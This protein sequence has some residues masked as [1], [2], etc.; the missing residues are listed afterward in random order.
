MQVTGRYEI[1]ERRLSTTAQPP[2]NKPKTIT[3]KMV[4][5]RMMLGF[6]L[7]EMPCMSD[8]GENEPKPGNSLQLVGHGL[9]HSHP[10]VDFA[11]PN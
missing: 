9:F 2:Q 11:S 1:G 8:I 5:Q 10:R 6:R 4:K 3:K 7:H